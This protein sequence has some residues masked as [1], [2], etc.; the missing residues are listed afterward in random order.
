MERPGYEVEIDTSREETSHEKA[1][2]LIGFDRRVVDFGCW[3]GFVARVLKERGCAV[4]GIEIDGEAAAGAEEHCDTVVVGDLDAMDLGSA[5]EG[6]Y[7]VGYFGDVLEH[8]KDPR[9][10]LAAMREKLGPEGFVVVSVPN[11]AHASVRLSL[12]KGQFDYSDTGILDATHLRFYTKESICDLLESAGYLV[13]AVDWVERKL[14]RG[15]LEQA[16]DPLG[17]SNM[18][19]VVKAFSEWEAVAFQYVIK[20]VPA[21]R[22]GQLERIS[23]EKMKA[24]YRL[25][26]LE[27]D[28]A[29]YKRMAEDAARLEAQVESLEQ[30][31]EK[32]GEY[33]R[34]LL[35]EL[36]DKDA[37]I[38]MLEEGVL[39]SRQSLDECKVRMA[40]MAEML[41]QFNAASQ[42]KSPTKRR[43]KR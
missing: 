6:E 43:R 9:R 35:G 33:T 28:L 21:S 18:E 5:L 29:V 26:A 32:N 8:L 38:A 36:S 17:L 15:Q 11:V 14:D 37:H 34:K 42:K 40:E 41:G 13:T 16:L 31:I 4:T 1:I 30:E 7:D 3:N 39:D 27:Q 20:A 10:V 2:A 19:E 24:E 25:R 22:E 12:L 23:E